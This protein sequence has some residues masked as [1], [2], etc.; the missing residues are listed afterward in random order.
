VPNNAKLYDTTGF[1][2][3]AEAA[4][5]GGAFKYSQALLGAEILQNYLYISKNYA[6]YYVE[7]FEGGSAVGF[8]KLTAEEI[9]RNI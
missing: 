8:L 4:P 5:G 7:V 9:T 2:L 1:S 3:Y 6:S